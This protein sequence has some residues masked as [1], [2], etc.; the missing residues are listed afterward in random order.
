MVFRPETGP[1]TI[2]AGSTRT[3][4]WL[5]ERR[6]RI[7]LW[8]AVI[9]GFLLVVHAIPRWPALLVAVAVMALYFF[10]GRHLRTDT[11][12][13]VAW[14]AAASQALVAL[15]PVLV[16]IVGT[17]A[18]VAVALLAVLALVFLFTDRR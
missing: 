4:R 2:E 16:I 13:H 9:E 17:V 3:G 12:R 7:A 5:R 1:R 10:F 18:L 15:I 14:V 6:L 11:G 8:I